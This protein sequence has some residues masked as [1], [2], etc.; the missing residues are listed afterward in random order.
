MNKR[1]LDFALWSDWIEQTDWFPIE[2]W[3]EWAV[4]SFFKPH[5]NN[6]ERFTLFCF[7]VR[8]GLEPNTAARFILWH[9]T[10]DE[11]A[12][13]QLRVLVQDFFG[14][15]GEYKQA[16]IYKKKLFNLITGEV[17]GTGF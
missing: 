15:N 17:D 12:H 2:R 5:K 1:D 16:A 13:K 7:F 10:Y 3:P 4:R 6:E 11:A 9:N 8:S 14:R